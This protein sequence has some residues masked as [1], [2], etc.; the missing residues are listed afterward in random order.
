MPHN[1]QAK[2]RDKRICRSLLGQLDQM[3]VLFFES[4]FE[5]IHSFINGGF[6]PSV[7][8][9]SWLAFLEEMIFY[10]NLESGSSLPDPPATTESRRIKQCTEHFS[11]MPT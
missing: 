4:Y 10:L 6:F 9:Q 1:E 8:K 2:G 7:F 3:Y 5:I 11:L